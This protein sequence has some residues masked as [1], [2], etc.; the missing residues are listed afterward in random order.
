MVC[1]TSAF[2]LDGDVVDADGVSV[3]SVVCQFFA[4]GFEAG[5]LAGERVDALAAERL[6]HGAVLQGAEVAVE[7]GVG[8]GDLGVEC[9]A[10]LFPAGSVGVEVGGGLADR[11]ADEVGLLS[12]SVSWSSTAASSAGVRMRWETAVPATKFADLLQQ[13]DLIRGRDPQAAADLRH[14]PSPRW[15]EERRALDAGDSATDAA[16]D[17]YL[18]LATAPCTRRSA[19]SAVDTLTRQLSGLKARREELTTTTRHRAPRLDDI[20]ALQANVAQTIRDGDPPTREAAASKR[21]VGEIRVEGHDRISP[22]VPAPGWGC[23]AGARSSTPRG[24]RTPATSVKGWR[25]NRY[26]MGAGGARVARGYTCSLDRRASH[27]APDPRETMR[28]R[29]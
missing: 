27:P 29:V 15:E 18:R 11:V 25:A 12:R 17:R 21:L 24:N 10:L 1:A 6:G 22:T 8:S 4:S 20:A 26:T 9:S 3:V 28:V 23:A 7:R 19:A 13:T 14:R 2:R 5:E 16:L